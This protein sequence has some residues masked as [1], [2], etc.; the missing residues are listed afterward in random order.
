MATTSIGNDRRT[1]TA[2][3]RYTDA[4]FMRDDKH[5]YF[6]NDGDTSV[7]W[8]STTGR[9]VLAGTWHLSGSNVQLADNQQLQFG[10]G[11][12]VYMYSSDSKL[13]AKGLPHV[14]A[15]G[16]DRLWVS[17]GYLKVSSG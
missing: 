13:V 10:N 15:A 12:D 9:L 3:E 16:S 5:F 4:V 7:Y 6:G 1:G 11:S 2:M 8:S 17:N 14:Y